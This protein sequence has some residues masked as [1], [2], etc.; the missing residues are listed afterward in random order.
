MDKAQTLEKPFVIYSLS[1]C[2]LLWIRLVLLLAETEPIMSLAFSRHQTSVTRFLTPA[3][4][5][6]VLSS[7][8]MILCCVSFFPLTTGTNQDREEAS[9]DGLLVSGNRSAGAGAG[10]KQLT[11]CVSAEFTCFSFFP[12]QVRTMLSKRRHVPTN[13]SEL[14][15]NVSQSR[16]PRKPQCGLFR[17]KCTPG[18]LQGKTSKCKGL[19]E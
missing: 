3:C 6:P 13:W 19:W 9:G 7:S 8:V 16:V 11:S 5:R 4:P 1:F 12:G 10:E 17:M 15:E 14:P 2:Q 18:Q